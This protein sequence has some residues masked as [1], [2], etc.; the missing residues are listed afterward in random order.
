LDVGVIS[1]E[2][3]SNEEAPHPGQVEDLLDN[4]YAAKHN[5]SLDKHRGQCSVVGIAMLKKEDI[6][7]LIFDLG[8]M[9]LYDE[10]LDV[11]PNEGG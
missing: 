6:D 8:D 5:E 9:S 7:W 1:H 11:C 4:N 2:D 3:S 10:H